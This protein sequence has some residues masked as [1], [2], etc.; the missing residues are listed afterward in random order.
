MIGFIIGFQDVIIFRNLFFTLFHKI[1]CWHRI[2][3][4]L[5]T[6]LYFFVIVKL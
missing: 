1:V 5:I 2:L 6:S 4:T 3:A